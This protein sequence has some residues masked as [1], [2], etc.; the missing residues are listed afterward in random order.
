[1]HA[2]AEGQ[3]SQIQLARLLHVAPMTV[4]RWVKELKEHQETKK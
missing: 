1:M 3:M 4:N 2:V